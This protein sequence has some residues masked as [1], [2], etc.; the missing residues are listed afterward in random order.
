METWLSSSKH[1]D[2]VLRGALWHQ[3]EEFSSEAS[4][5]EHLQRQPQRSGD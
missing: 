5:G 2:N 1:V 4:V 3:W